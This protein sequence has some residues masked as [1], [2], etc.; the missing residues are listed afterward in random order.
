MSRGIRVVHTKR[1]GVVIITDRAEFS[2]SEVEFEEDGDV[3]IDGNGPFDPREIAAINA[4]VQRRVARKQSR[5]GAK[6][7]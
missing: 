4:I 7:S 6:K 5:K 2:P 1:G 3:M